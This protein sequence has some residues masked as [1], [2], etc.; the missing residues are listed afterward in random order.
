MSLTCVE[1]SINFSTI[2]QEVSLRSK[3]A[4][5]PPRLCPECRRQR[6]LSWVNQ[7]NLF[8]STCAG[9]GAPII[10]N[11]PPESS[12]KVYSQ[13]YWYSD[14][15]DSREYGRPFDFSKPFFEQFSE[16]QK[17]V[18]RPALFTDYLGDENSRYTNYAAGNKNCYLIFQS[19]YSQ[20]CFYGYSVA[21]SKNTLDSYH[22][23][24]NELCYEAINSR[25]SFQSGFLRECESCSDSFFLDS[26]SSCTRCIFCS[27][28]RHKD[29]HIGNKPVT[30]AEYLQVRSQL[31]SF[32][33]LQKLR[34]E[35]ESFSKGFPR[36]TISAVRCE[37]VSGQSLRECRNAHLC[38]DCEGVESAL[39][40]TQCFNPSKEYLDCDGCG[41][42]E[43]IYEGHQS[44]MRGY[45][46]RCTLQC[47]EQVR[48][49]TY[50]DTCL[51]SSNLFGCV[52]L[53]RS[54][55]AIL[56]REYKPEEYHAL[57]PKI[58]SHMER[59]G[60]WGEFFP[61]RDSIVPYN[62]SMA[63]LR[64]P[65]SEG[66]VLAKKLRWHPREK[67][68][69]PSEPA[70]LIPD[71]IDETS[72]TITQRVFSCLNC[73]EPYRIIS[74]ELAFLRQ[75]GIALPRNCF[76]CRHQLRLES[77][78]PHKL[79]DRTCEECHQAISTA[80]DPK[81]HAQVLCER[82]FEGRFSA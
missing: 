38:F 26:C 2:S 80:H 11:F 77:R 4:V 10:T 47:I 66:E 63:S 28:L 73:N 5:P 20:D 24:E 9:S 43:L 15:Y 72:D 75:L 16:L 59:T 21:K 41:E 49:L 35:F 12:I 54:H 34:S 82:C 48:D 31:R 62:L 13:Q 25:H 67:R 50:C 58:I 14:N 6:R 36:K 33:A 18:P 22:S 37:E 30:E 56:N 64:H 79:W 7:L 71:R 69:Q 45:N 39:Y 52:G 19:G 3:F 23:I 65:L 70:S 17:V 76:H 55:Y 78:S 68:E 51:Q 42:G 81:K 8:R 57:V 40:C 60:E 44:G 61:M 32:T 46:L 29:L 27:H 1:C 74:Q 53:R